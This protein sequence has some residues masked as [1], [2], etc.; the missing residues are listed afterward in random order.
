MPFQGVSVV[1]LRQQFEGAN[2]RALCREFSVSPTTAYRWI[3]RYQQGG[4]AALHD[5]SRR[6]R[7]APRQTPP[8]VEALVVRLRQQHPAW[9]GRKLQRA[10]R[11][12]G[13]DAIPSVS[14]CTEILRRHGLL[15]AEEGRKH[16]AFQRF[17]AAAP[18]DLWQ[19]DFKGDVR[20][21]GQVVYPLPVLDDH[22]R[23]LLGVQTCHDQRTATVQSLLT[24]V[25][26]TYGLPRRIL[27][28]NG[29]PWGTVRAEGHLTTLGAWLVRLGIHLS[30]G[31]PRHPQTQG[32]IERTMRTLEAE[33]LRQ[34]T[35][36]HADALQ[37]ALDTWR[38]TYNT[39][40][41]HEALDLAT[42]VSRYTPSAIP[43]PETLPLIIYAQDAIVRKVSDAGVISWK[44]QPYKVSKALVGE[45]VELRPSEID[46]VYAVYYAHHRVRTLT[47][48]T[49]Q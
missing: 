9:G 45:A 26:R 4:L 14:T 27:A 11:N 30:H 2:V 24:A 23:F 37:A 6:P 40:R 41:P 33:V 34:S 21:P 48:R 15:D 38:F 32:K 20:L 3:N 10:L 7:H 8:E 1:D 18:N 28:D 22:S 12:Q 36:L 29:P 49:R 17:E 47:L 46:G 35:F 19:L 16:R 31:R 43:F 42:P 39:V 44:N 5:R 13:H 25:F